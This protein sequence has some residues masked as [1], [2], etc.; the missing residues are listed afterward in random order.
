M[1]SEQLKLLGNV[2]EF[3]NNDLK[4]KQMLDKFYVAT[5]LL[6]I[7]VDQGHNFNITITRDAALE[8]FDEPKD[9][10]IKDLLV[11]S[12]SKEFEREIK[13]KSKC[14]FYVNGDEF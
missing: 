11:I 6:K 8:V 14:V 4:N 7:I 9:R 10:K 13:Y 5:E 3:P 2:I 1:K 12:S